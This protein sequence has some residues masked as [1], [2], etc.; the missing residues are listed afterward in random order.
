M[1]GMIKLSICANLPPKRV[2]KA[3]PFHV[4]DGFCDAKLQNGMMLKTP[5]SLTN[6]RAAMA[7]DYQSNQDIEASNKNA[8]VQTRATTSSYFGHSFQTYDTRHTQDG[9]ACLSRLNQ[10]RRIS[11]FLLGCPFT[12][13]SKTPRTARFL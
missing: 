4:P 7:E 11:D 13:S 9:Q 2:G 10:V 12:S 3:A 5:S 1:N 6:W 8:L